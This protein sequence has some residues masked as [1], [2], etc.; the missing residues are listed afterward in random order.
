MTIDDDDDDDDDDENT[1][2]LRLFWKRL[3]NISMRRCHELND[4]YIH[5]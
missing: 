1:I 2:E 5:T 3:S 4:G